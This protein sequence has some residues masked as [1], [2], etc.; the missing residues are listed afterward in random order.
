MP[1]TAFPATPNL[2][3]YLGIVPENRQTVKRFSARLGPGVA[4]LQAAR[5]GGGRA[6]RGR[7]GGRLLRSLLARRGLLLGRRLERLKLGIDRVRLQLAARPA[8]AIAR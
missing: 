5:A 3:C 1:L 2:S 7:G 8:V 6:G 4:A